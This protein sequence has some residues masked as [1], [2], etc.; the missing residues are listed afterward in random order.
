MLLTDV[1]LCR[2][3]MKCD[4]DAFDLTDGAIEDSL[5]GVTASA[6]KELPSGEVHLLTKTDCGAKTR[7]L[8]IALASEKGCH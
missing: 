4:G 5:A 1:Q 3:R 8:W 7:G 2:S 6:R